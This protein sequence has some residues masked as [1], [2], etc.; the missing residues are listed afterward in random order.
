V[1][2]QP[3]EK[4]WKF[5]PDQS[6]AEAITKAVFSD[7]PCYYLGEFNLLHEG[8]SGR[9]RFQVLRVVRNDKLVTA[10]VPLGSAGDFTANQF[11]T[12]GGQVVDGH[13][14]AWH[15][16]AE[17]REMADEMRG[18]K[19]LQIEHTDLQHAFRNHA[20]EKK[21][22]PRRQSTFGRKGSLVRT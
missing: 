19:P 17:L 20:E 3:A 13:G 10:Y 22:W 9:V 8:R 15:T 5:K 1:T 6:L 4:V 11:Q 21:R 7:E 14:T 18:Q 12:W 16:V 2:L